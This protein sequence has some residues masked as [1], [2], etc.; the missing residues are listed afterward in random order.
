MILADNTSM[1]HIYHIA[2]NL[3]IIFVVLVYCIA[4][5][6]VFTVHFYEN[7]VLYCQQ[8]STLSVS[9]FFVENI[10]E[11]QLNSL[12]LVSSVSNYSFYF[13][14]ILKFSNDVKFHIEVS[15]AIGMQ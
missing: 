13:D 9:P 15:C 7:N 10:S 2:V 12:K 4:F 11:L 14:S 3:H 8:M 5:F 1:Y 6:S